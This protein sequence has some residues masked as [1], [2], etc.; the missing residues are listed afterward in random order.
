MHSSVHIF[1]SVF[2]ALLSS[3][4]P[5]FALPSPTEVPAPAPSVCDDWGLSPTA[6]WRGNAAEQICALHHG[7]S[8][9]SNTTTIS[10]NVVPL[11]KT[12]Y[13]CKLPYDIIKFISCSSARLY[14]VPYEAS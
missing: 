13:V 10:H 2:F 11:D 1:L 4:A 7:Y 6:D 14:E 9:K 3:N 8:I 5:A 12:F